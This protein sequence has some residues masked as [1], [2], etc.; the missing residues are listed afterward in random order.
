MLIPGRRPSPCRKRWRG[1]SFR[2][3]LVEEVPQHERHHRRQHQYD[4]G[5]HRD[6]TTE[7]RD[8][9][10]DPVGLRNRFVFRPEDDLRQIVDD[11]DQGVGEQELVDLLL[12]LD[13]AQQPRLDRRRDDR[14]PQRRRQKRD[15]EPPRAGQVQRQCVDEVC[16]EHVQRAVGEVQDVQDAEDQREAGGDRKRN[17]ACRRALNTCTVRN[18][19]SMDPPIPFPFEWIERGRPDGGGPGCYPG[20]AGLLVRLLRLLPL[21][22]GVDHLV[23]REDLGVRDDRDRVVLVPPVSPTM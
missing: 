20:L 7:D 6:G 11:E 5:V 14:H 3:G 4:E 18:D 23:R 10:G 13:P 21:G 15:Q 2:P 19:R 16:P 17:A 22:Q 8:R 1:R 12:P 9:P